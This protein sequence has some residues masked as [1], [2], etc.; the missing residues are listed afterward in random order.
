MSD[1]FG[2]LAVPPS[3][4]GLVGDPTLEKL[5]AFLRAVLDDVLA[6]AWAASTP[7]PTGNEVPV[8]KTVYTHSW[9]GFGFNENALPALFVW[10]DSGLQEQT[11]S[12]WLTD[13]TIIRA[14][15]VLPPA[16]QEM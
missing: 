7:A 1:N 6:T 10:R 9:E 11:A 5:G 8:V 4:S 12:D 15:W 13:Q 2:G 14:L 3:T 16:P